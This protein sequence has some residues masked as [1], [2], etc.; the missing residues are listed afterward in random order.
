MAELQEQFEM[1]AAE[2]SYHQHYA[3]EIEN[4]MKAIAQVESEM[5]RTIQAL[6]NAKDDN[7]SLFNIGSGVFIKGQLKDT[8]KLLLNVGAN[9]FVESSTQD[10][11]AF[12][13]EKKKELEDAKNDLIKSMEAIS[14]R[15]KEID[16]EARRL[17]KE[18]APEQ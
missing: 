8:N 18:Q 16:I 2:A 14:N 5:D 15:L 6:K 13:T 10:S 12:L 3:K 7:T 1:L 17:M 9:V 4:Q 11:I